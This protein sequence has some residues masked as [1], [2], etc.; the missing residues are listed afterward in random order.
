MITAPVF[1]RLSEISSL[2]PNDHHYWPANRLMFYLFQF[3]SLPWLYF[4]P[5][6][7]GVMIQ[8]TAE[9]MDSL[10]QALRD[11]KDFSITCGKA[12][13]E[14]NQELVCIQWTEDDHNFNKGWDGRWRAGRWRAGRWRRWS[15]SRVMELMGSLL[16]SLLCSNKSLCTC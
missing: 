10:R 16:H 9:T 8:I 13:Q 12:D 15:M 1:N 6:S 7:D 11:M 3:Y 14:E 5:S 4:S 2:P